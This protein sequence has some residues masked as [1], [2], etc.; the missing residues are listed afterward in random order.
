MVPDFSSSLGDPLER[1]EHIDANHMEMCRFSSREDPGYT[2][3][4]GEL[5]SQVEDA[6]QQHMIARRS[7]DKGYES[8]T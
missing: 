4:G 3:V 7:S 6:H 1:A 2:Q 8:K 5:A